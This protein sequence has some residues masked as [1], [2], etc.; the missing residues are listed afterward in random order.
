M[1]VVIDGRKIAKE[2]LGD[3]KK[4]PVS[5]KWLGSIITCENEASSKFLRQ[6]EK[7]AKK[8]KISTFVYRRN[9]ENCPTT[10]DLSKEIMEICD[11]P[12]VGGINVHLPLPPIYNKELVFAAINPLKD[13]NRLNSSNNYVLPPSVM[14]LEKI[15]GSLNYDISDKKVVVIGSG[16]L[17]GAPIAHYLNGRV[18]HLMVFRSKNNLNGHSESEVLKE[19]D[20]VI[21]GVGKSG[22]LKSE[23]LNS[24][25]GVI[26]FGNGDLEISNSD[27]NFY[28][29]TPGGTGPILT[30]CLFEN[31]YHLT[32]LQT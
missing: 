15:L 24:N 16:F 21:T 8:L 6:R 17:I 10:E 23:M 29:P 25:A 27:L 4:R 2:I 7:I 31:F 11:Y 14:A 20:L 13:I 9:E 30:A 12:G 18:G 19:A 32:E 5:G 3:L 22:I 1:A 28:T 26:D